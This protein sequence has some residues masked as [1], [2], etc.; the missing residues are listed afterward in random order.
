M[1]IQN[2]APIF[3]AHIPGRVIELME[4]HHNKRII[5]VS[6]E[7]VIRAI[8]LQIHSIYS[9][10]YLFIFSIIANYVEFYLD[11]ESYLLI[12]DCDN[13]LYLFDRHFT[14]QRILLK[15]EKYIWK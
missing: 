1:G 12:F 11:D 13:D 6:S 15:K 10:V 8:I 4:T 5:F 2:T 7:S 9:H 14:C 3:F